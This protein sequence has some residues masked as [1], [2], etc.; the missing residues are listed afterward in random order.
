MPVLAELQWPQVMA[1]ILV[2][3]L[4]AVLYRVFRAFRCREVR[5]GARWAKGVP[6]HTPYTED[7]KVQVTPAPS[8]RPLC[9]IPGY[10]PAAGERFVTMAGAYLLHTAPTDVGIHQHVPRCRVVMAHADG[11]G[12]IPVRLEWHIPDEVVYLTPRTWALC[13]HYVAPKTEVHHG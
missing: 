5:F 7:A 4:L 10:A 11:P 13:L 1:I 6:A 12:R 2:L 3:L 9:A 8:Q